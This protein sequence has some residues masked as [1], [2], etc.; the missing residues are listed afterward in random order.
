MYFLISNKMMMKKNDDDLQRWR[1]ENGKRLKLSSPRIA[2]HARSCYIFF[3]SLR[4]CNLHLSSLV[5]VAHLGSGFIHT[6]MHLSLQIFVILP[7]FPTRLN[8]ELSR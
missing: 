1:R 6:I 3:F 8:A 7:L 5:R 2:N 4:F